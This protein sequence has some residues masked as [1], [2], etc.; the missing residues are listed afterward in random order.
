MGINLLLLPTMLA[1]F[2]KTLSKLCTQPTK[3]ENDEACLLLRI[4]AGVK[5]TT[6]YN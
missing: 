3:M 1:H 4:L 2:T 5:M 6:L